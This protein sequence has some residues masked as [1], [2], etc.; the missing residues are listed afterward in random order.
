MNSRPEHS[1]SPGAAL[2]IDAKA[3]DFLIRR[4]DRGNWTGE[5][6]AA[7][8]NWLSQ[9]LAHKAAYWRLESIW[10]RADRLHALK[11]LKAQAKREAP[12]RRALSFSI[13]A[14]VVAVI[15]L[16]ASA[17]FLML[18]GG[19]KTYATQ[20]GGRELI[21][22]SDGSQIELNTDT[23]L[24]TNFAGG[25][26]QVELVK[27]EALFRIK[28]DPAHPFTVM[29]EG[30]RVTDLGTEFAIREEGK[31]V[32]VAL[33]EGRARISP[34]PANGASKSAV[35]TPGD[36]A[37]ATAHGLS[38]VH[39]SQEQLE[40]DLSWRRGVLVF[41]HATLEQVAKEY[42]RYNRQKIVIADSEAG[43]RVINA[44]L[45][46]T[47]VGAFARMAQNFLGLTVEYRDDAVVISR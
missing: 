4:A 42:N 26:R 23:V 32:K 37:V 20:V 1:D 22:L 35:L 41:H 5:D 2:E 29:A 18:Q 16:S 12:P 24:R 28:H 45:P 14:A 17:G 21:K 40:S 34:A 36:E 39:Q 13:A 6:E 19:A 7:F 44:T 11:S 30:Q 46:A 33:L 3:A 15:A 43:A 9:S 38:I 31:R 47:D 8:D 27:G 10:D 25:Q